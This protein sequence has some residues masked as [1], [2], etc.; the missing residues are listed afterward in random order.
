MDEITILKEAELCKPRS[1]LTSEHQTPHQD[2]GKKGKM[3]KSRVCSVTS[4][5]SRKRSSITNPNYADKEDRSSYYIKSGKKS[6]NAQ[7]K[8]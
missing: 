7:F 2:Q 4:N 6:L 3:V 8:M 1:S 5:Y